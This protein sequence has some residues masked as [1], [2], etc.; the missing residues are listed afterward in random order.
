MLALLKREVDCSN[1]LASMVVLGVC[2]L[3]SWPLIYGV[4]RESA[5]SPVLFNIYIKPL[6]EV[7][8]ELGLHNHQYADGM[9][10]Y[11]KLVRERG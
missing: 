6:G 5:L 10:L 3:A 11:L 8:Q 4:P 9:H 7:T 1:G 2:C